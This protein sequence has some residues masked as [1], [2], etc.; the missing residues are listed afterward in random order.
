MSLAKIRWIILSAFVVALA[1][2]RGELSDDHDRY[3]NIFGLPLTGGIPNKGAFLGRA[4]LADGNAAAWAQVDARRAGADAE[5]HPVVTMT[6]EKGG[7]YL[8]SLEPG[9]YDIYVR[10]PVG[11]ATRY[12]AQVN[13]GDVTVVESIKLLP[14]ARISGHA[15]LSNQPVHTG[16]V[17]NVPGTPFATFTDHEGAYYLDIPVGTYAFRAD[18]D[19]FQPS[20]TEPK[21]V[22]GDMT[23]DFL[24]EENPWPNGKVTAVTEDGFVVRGL[25]TTIKLEPVEGVRY[26]RLSGEY[27]TAESSTA[28]RAWKALTNEITLE[29]EREGV[30]SIS[31]E[32]MDQYGKTSDQVYVR[33]FNTLKDQSWR[34]LHGEVK[35][36]VVLTA[37]SKT[38]LL[39]SGQY[40]YM[41][42]SIVGSKAQQLS[43]ESGT[44]EESSAQAS[45]DTVP[46]DDG[47][48]GNEY[49]LF[50]DAVTIE[51][52]AEIHGTAIF[53]GGLKVLGTKESPVVWTAGPTEQYGMHNTLNVTGDVGI[54]YAKFD[55]VDLE[56]FGETANLVVADTVLGR[57]SVVARQRFYSDRRVS[58]SVTLDHVEFR[59]G[60]LGMSCWHS[61][62]G[63]DGS[64]TAPGAGSDG[65]GSG[66]EVRAGGTMTFSVQNSVIDQSSLAL[67]C[68]NFEN[69]FLT[70]FVFKN[71]NEFGASET[72][73]YFDGY[74]P[75]PAEL[76]Y[77]VASSYFLAP[78]R[79]YRTQGA[80]WPA[81][82]GTKAETPFTDV[83]VR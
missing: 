28:R 38:L 61:K 42:D 36:Q 48:F 5:A 53:A 35:S 73:F 81:H 40:G 80:E 57:S 31:V 4:L 70:S 3:M 74:T 13:G 43:E 8:A 11:Q 1:C 20:E 66:R 65:S 76:R 12:Q 47:R 64:G 22:S 77:D 49:T 6:N 19:A 51:A 52:G 34:V 27:K 69:L 82:F 44:T 55:G 14:T 67:K 62:S 15:K 39:G 83:G 32:F 18:K 75:L 7:F 33:F 21:E 45:E 24:L 41:A 26:Y 50:W 17:V 78:D 58:T 71:N 16:I 72:G 79:L 30:S 10:S 46:I 37:G 54:S 9:S 23:L 59:D 56:T 25:K 2:S 63:Y 60:D 29:F 68:V